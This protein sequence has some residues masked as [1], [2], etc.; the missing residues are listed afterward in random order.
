MAGK[1]LELEFQ[2]RNPVESKFHSLQ[3]VQRS[4]SSCNR[5][6]TMRGDIFDISDSPEEAPPAVEVEQCEVKQ[7]VAEAVEEAPSVTEAVSP[8]P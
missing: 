8:A 4:S 3:I 6:S 2:D 1:N 5:G 7:E